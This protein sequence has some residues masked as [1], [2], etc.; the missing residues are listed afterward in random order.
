MAEDRCVEKAWSKHPEIR[1]EARKRIEDLYRTKFDIEGQVLAGEIEGFTEAYEVISD[2]GLTDQYKNHA[3]AR[4]SPYEKALR[5]SVR[6]VRNIQRIV[7]LKGLSPS[8]I[9]WGIVWSEYTKQHPQAR[10]KNPAVLK[11]DYHRALGDPR[12]KEKLFDKEYCE[13]GEA[14]KEIV[15][16][17]EDPRI[18]ELAMK[19]ALYDIGEEYGEIVVS[20]TV[21]ATRATMELPPDRESEV[22]FSEP[23]EK[24]E[25]RPQSKTKGEAQNERVN[26]AEKAEVA[27]SL[28]SI[29]EK[30]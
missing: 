25:V 14:V 27:G 12:V 11:A 26:R 30:Q 28:K 6:L 19:A 20:G 18:A 17:E 21:I 24:G 7:A 23:A 5:R 9:D 13:H 3:K 16:H 29:L 22:S 2:S 10:I 15:L 1:A 4:I 8:H